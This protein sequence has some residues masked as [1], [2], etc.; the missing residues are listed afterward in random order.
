[1][2]VQR[3]EHLRFALKSGEAVRIQGKNFGQDLER[4]VAIQP[5]IARAIHF[6]HAPGANQRQDFVRAESH[7]GGE[8][9]SC[10]GP[11]D[12]ATRKP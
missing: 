1:M 9:R 3:G 7:A 2:V 8:G 12:Y 4:D 10:Q 6:A 5:G 11:C